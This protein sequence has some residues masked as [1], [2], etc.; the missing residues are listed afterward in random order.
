MG[1]QNNGVWTPLRAALKARKL[2]LTI[3]VYVC[4]SHGSLC[5][6]ISASEAECHSPANRFLLGS[7]TQTEV[8]DLLLLTLIWSKNFQEIYRKGHA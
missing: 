6:G 4:V 1:I 2:F 7:F 3:Q 8:R 5:S